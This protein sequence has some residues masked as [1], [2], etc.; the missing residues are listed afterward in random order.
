M[1]MVKS[2][3]G[4]PPSFGRIRVNTED[5]ELGQEKILPVTKMSEE[6]IKHLI[7]EKKDLDIYNKFLPF[8]Y[9][10]DLN[11]AE[12]TGTTQKGFPKTITVSI[13]KCD[14]K[15]E[16]KC[17]SESTMQKFW[18][19]GAYFAIYAIETYLDLNNIEDPI[20]QKITPL[21]N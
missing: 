2:D 17:E 4:M 7:K 18:N 8:L 1:P 11:E 16:L 9:D 20:K 6:R 13:E 15:I 14:P 5:L 12:I 3:K 21:T 19:E 10:I